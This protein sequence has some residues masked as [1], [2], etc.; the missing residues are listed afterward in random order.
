[1]KICRG[2]EKIILAATNAQSGYVISVKGTTMTSG[3]NIINA[4]AA[5][6]VSRPGTAQFGLNLRANTTPSGGSNPSGPGFAVPDPNYNVPNTYRFKD[7]DTLVSTTL[8]DDRRLFTASYIVNVPKGQAPGIYVS[9]MTYICV[10]T[11]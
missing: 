2:R 1:M 9:T 8:P 10:G 7:G 5:N 11:F 6:D 3:T 4:L